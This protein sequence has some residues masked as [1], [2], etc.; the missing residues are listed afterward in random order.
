[1]RVFFIVGS[2]VTIFRLKTRVSV[3]MSSL[4]NFGPRL[5]K[6]KK[7]SLLLRTFDLTSYLISNH[8]SAR[9]VL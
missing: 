8:F 4:T 6:R 9:F 7:G 2:L 3:P 5:L 1:M